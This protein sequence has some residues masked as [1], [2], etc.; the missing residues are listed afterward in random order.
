MEIF[1]FIGVVV[2]VVVFLLW[3]SGAG[4]SRDVDAPIQGMPNDLRNKYS[5]P[6]SGGGFYGGGDGD[7]GGGAG[8]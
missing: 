2:A 5:A 4:V 1:A 8:T 3:R 7:A 6:G